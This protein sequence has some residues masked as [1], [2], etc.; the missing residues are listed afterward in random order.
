MHF[1]AS[2]P[3]EI[4][5]DR[6]VNSSVKSADNKYLSSAVTPNRIQYLTLPPLK[7]LL[8]SHVASLQNAAGF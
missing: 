3:A 4:F 1:E 2:Y 6:L 8:T 7:V 5:K